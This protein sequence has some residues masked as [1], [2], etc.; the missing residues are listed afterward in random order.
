MATTHT[1]G[2]AFRVTGPDGSRP[3]RMLDRDEPVTLGRSSQAS[4]RLD[5]PGVSR[6]HALL[7]PSPDGGWT[8]RDLGSRN[9]VFVNAQPASVHPL[10]LGDVIEIGPFQVLFGTQDNGDDAGSSLDGSTSNF[11]VLEDAE[12]S[13]SRLTQVG[14]PK[15]DVQQ[16]RAVQ[17]LG[18][19]LLQLADEQQRRERLC[20]F[21]IEPGLQG[22][23]AAVLRVAFDENPP[24]W[25]PPRIIAGPIYADPADQDF[26]I[27]RSL[28]ESVVQTH[29]AVLATRS[30][31]EVGGASGRDAAPVIELSM[32]PETQA[33]S[34]IGCP[35]PAR[36][37]SD[38]APGGP[39]SELSDGLDVLYAVLPD[40]C[41]TGEWLALAALAVEQY[42][43]VERAWSARQAAERQAKTEAEL[44]RARKVQLSL[45][46]SDPRVEGLELAL[47]YEP[48]LSVGGDYVDAVTL[49]DGRALL[50]VMDVCG[51]GMA[52]ALISSSLHTFI[53]AGLNTTSDPVELINALNR[54]LCDTMD[55]SSFVTGIAVAVDPATGECECVNAGHPPAILQSAAPGARP[56]GNPSPQ[57]GQPPNTAEPRYSDQGDNVPLGLIS[58]PLVGHRFTLA[59]GEVL[60]LYS[61]G[62]TEIIADDG[63]WIGP[64]GL[65]GHL[66][67][68]LREDP[69][70]DLTAVR[71]GLTRRLSDIQGDRAPDDD[72]TFLL[73]RRA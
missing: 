33:S 60:A 3:W 52:A 18:R 39:P 4:V 10:Q 9:G 50:V 25:K 64:E 51:K 21:M 48:C 14:R 13:I 30:G 32:A 15:V 72:A 35:L 12:A 63:K 70:L 8:L 17:T 46:P 68:A 71:A 26:Y 67:A 58:D 40:R 47:H 20:A 7:E 42:D 49:A 6:R 59:P 65:A 41:G 44:A 69:D 31:I 24:G 5:D 53:R 29:E 22:R 66:G 73:V 62:L 28:L 54:Y 36:L 27:S 38:D 57:D 45:V 1:S 61:D 11:T 55:G 56:P 2:W 43:L 37:E 34:V 16:L 19:D 23:H